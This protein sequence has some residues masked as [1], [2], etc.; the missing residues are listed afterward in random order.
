ML[1]RRADDMKNMKLLFIFT[2]GTIGSTERLGVREADL[3]KPYAI[4]RAYR[5]RYGI[6]FEYDTAEPYCELSENLTGEHIKK[7]AL[8]VKRGA[9]EGYDGI[10]VTHG[11]D[12]LQYSAAALGY[13]LGLDSIPVCIVSANAP[14]ESEES[15]GLINLRAAIR[16]IE[17]GAGRGV[18]CVYANAQ[19]DGFFEKSASKIENVR[20]RVSIHRATRLMPPRPFSDESASIFGQ[21][22][23]WFD[24]KMQLFRNEKYSECSDELSPIDTSGLCER[25][26]EALVLSPAVGMRY[27]SLDGVRWVLLNTYHSGTLDVKSAGALEFYKSAKML[28]VRIYALGAT[29][30]LSYSSS[31]DFSA[32]GIIPI[33]NISPPAAYMKLWLL[34]SAGRCP[35]DE[36]ER[37]LGGD[38][39]V[40]PNSR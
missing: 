1:E 40:E 26:D 4:L 8:A 14:I 21:E 20:G 31:A 16:F 17:L 32:L 23:A 36:I 10:I 28:G 33:R 25:F 35:D 11:T 27:P 19:R 38:V 37:S 30:G 7:L 12:T 39:F 22:Y 15:N 18:F 3:G 13:A 6:D 29:D 2:G 24:E 34:K 9:A 5:E